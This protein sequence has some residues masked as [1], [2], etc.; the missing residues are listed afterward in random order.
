M[1]A[2]A[3]NVSVAQATDMICVTL[4]VHL[5]SG[6]KRAVRDQMVK[7]NPALADMPPR[8]LMTLGSRAVCDPKE[9]K[10]FQKLKRKAEVLLKGMGLPLLGTVGIPMAK[11]DGVYS[12]LVQIQDEFN[13]AIKDFEQR[14]LD[15]VEEWRNAPQNTRW[16]ELTAEIPDLHYVIG[17]LSFDF[18]LCR[19]SAPSAEEDSPVN[20]LYKKQ[21]TGLKGELFA[22]I[23]AEAQT[24]MTKYLTGK[25]ADGVV[26]K[27][28]TI[29]WKTVRPLKRMAEKLRT[30][31]FLDGSVRP[32]AEMIE[33][34]LGLLPKDGAIEGTNLAH[35][36][37]LA[38]ILAVPT[39][40]M[41][42]AEIAFTSSGAEAFEQWGA[43][44]LTPTIAQ[45]QTAHVVL[46]PQVAANEVEEE[47]VQQTLT[48]P[49]HDATPAGV[50]F[51]DF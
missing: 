21:M 18:H 32:L 33:H 37:S 29:T 41:D 38:R 4:D 47:S 25:R 30:F 8:E 44:S 9:I 36:W 27:R 50:Q 13:A 28:E 16:R 3:Q 40:A 14:Y 10:V 34:V 48:T 45:P 20:G 35:I 42:A 5:W 2:I 49:V 43:I 22:D 19:V 23:S 51:V 6:R 7:I 12:D 39:D 24:L 15:V 11:L 31:A 26:S 17:R 1:S 46:A